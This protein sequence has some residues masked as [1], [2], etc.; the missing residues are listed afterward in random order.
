MAATRNEMVSDAFE[1]L[2][3]EAGKLTTKGYAERFAILQEAK[4]EPAAPFEELIQ[5]ALIGLV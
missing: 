3:Q 4:N 1:T 5:E 2:A